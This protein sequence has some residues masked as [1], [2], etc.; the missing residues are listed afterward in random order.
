M[1]N[2]PSYLQ[3]KS[4]KTQLC[5]PNTNK[6]ESPCS[7]LSMILLQK[8]RGERSASLTTTTNLAVRWFLPWRKKWGTKLLFLVGWGMLLFKVFTW[9]WLVLSV[10]AESN[11]ECLRWSM[12]AIWVWSANCPAKTWS[13]EIW[14]FL[15]VLKMW[16][17]TT[18]LT[19]VGYWLF[20]IWRN[21]N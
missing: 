2:L 1:W 9:R 5:S 6:W 19:M 13:R 4:T 15:M 10:G 8:Q 20:T 11:T 14:S 18:N 7:V 3:V 17:S 16:N 21:N 12:I